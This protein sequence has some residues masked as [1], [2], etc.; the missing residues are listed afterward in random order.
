M[1][2]VVGIGFLSS[3]SAT[4][5]SKAWSVF[6]SVGLR[7]PKINHFNLS[8]LTGQDLFPEKLRLPADV[9]ILVNECDRA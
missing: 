3:F 4:S 9:E 7:S 5:N 8:A 2:S 1:D 6:I